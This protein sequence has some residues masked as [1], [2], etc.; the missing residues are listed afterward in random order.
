MKEQIINWLT[1]PADI[2][3][4]IAMGV[5]FMVAGHFAMAWVIKKS[6]ERTSLL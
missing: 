5:L 3:T 2:P 6:Y 4:A 1:S